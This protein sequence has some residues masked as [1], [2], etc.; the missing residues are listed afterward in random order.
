MLFLQLDRSVPSIVVAKTNATHSVSAAARDLG[1]EPKQEKGRASRRL[2]LGNSAMS[3]AGIYVGRKRFR[4]AVMKPRDAVSKRPELDYPFH[5]W[6]ATVTYCRRIC[7][8]KRKV[9]LSQVPMSPE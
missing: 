4:I 2:W 8:K 9:N 5:D 7:F 3:Q 1:R 6:T